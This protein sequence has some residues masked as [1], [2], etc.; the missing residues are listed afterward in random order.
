[1]ELVYAW[2][3]KFRNYKEVELNFSERFIIN[4]DHIKKSINIVANA[5]YISIYPEYITNINAVVGKN[6]VGKTNL[7]DAIGLKSNDRNKNKAE[8]E[9]RYKQKNKLGY[10]VNDD[11]EAEIKHSIYFFLYYMGKDS[12]NQDLFC[13]EGNDIESFQSMIKN[14]SGISNGYWKSKYWFAF[15]C[16]YSEGMLI[17]QSDLH[18]RPRDYKLDKD[19]DIEGINSDCRS[20]QDKVAIISLR[21]KLNPKYYDYSSTKPEDDYKISVPRRVAKFQSKLLVMKIKML[22]KQ[23]HRSKKFMFRDD[24]YTLKI[25][26]NT[27]FLIDD[28]KDEKKLGIQYSYKDLEGRKK[29]IC[30]VFESFVQYFFNEIN[31]SLDNE[32]KKNIEMQTN[33]LSVK[34]K[35]LKGY[36]DYYVDI[37]KIIS[38]NYFDNEEEIQHIL[39]GFSDFADELSINKTI[40]FHKDYISLDITKQMNLDKVLKVIELTVDERMKSN[41]N[42]IVPVFGGFFDCSI[43]NLSDGESAYLGF[44]ASLYEQVSLLTPSKDKYVILLDEPE[45]RMHPELTRNFMNELILFLGDISEGRKKFQIITSTHS[46]FILSDI[47]TSNIIYLEKDKDG[48]CRNVN[49]G[50]NTFGTNIHTLLKDGFFMSSTMGEFATNKIREIISLINNGNLE[51]IDLEQK[52]EWL[53][54]INSIGEPLIQ[55][56]LMKMYNDKFQLNYTELYN[57]NLKLR[58][59]LNKYEEPRKINETIDIL[60]NQVKQLQTYISELED[61]NE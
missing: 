21:E 3:E 12:N 41:F 39:N 49:R 7:L 46:P 24:R 16:Y 25:N 42:E 37:I 29:E 53:Y 56:R 1:M 55:N 2:V 6:G 4:Y 32:M 38:D 47:V 44:Y 43:E 17:H 48:Y 9:I 50:L 14:E 51:S 8:F 18:E 59:K 19:E 28:F 27:Y 31:S 23:L 26:Y 15:T 58:R 13:V 5:A 11:I 45:A 34:R 33:L 30:K 20:E 54:I 36:R 40:K 52:N 61:K 10:I 35:S 57:E 60:K 22:Y